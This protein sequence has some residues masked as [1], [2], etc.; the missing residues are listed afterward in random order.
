MQCP[1]CKTNQPMSFRCRSCGADLATR[2]GSPRVS[3]AG[4]PAAAA[5]PMDGGFDAA[6]ASAAAPVIYT[7]GLLASRGSRLAAAILDGLIVL[8]SMAP[9]FLLMSNGAGSPEEMLQKGAMAAMVGPFLL[10]LY[11]MIILTRDGQTLGKKIMKIRIVRFDDGSNPG[12]GRVIGRRVFLNG[13]LG[14]IP[15]YALVDVL[16]I[17]GSQQRCVHDLIAG[18]K[19]V[20]A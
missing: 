18:T 10:G 13:L 2:S 17:F 12:F 16:F 6:V 20:Q 7:S 3:S 5:V 14:Y 4:G 19:V 1:S 15:F 11:Y 9:G 8:A